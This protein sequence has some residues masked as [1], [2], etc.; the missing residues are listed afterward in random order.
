MA[1]LAC[2]LAVLWRSLTF[3]A[4]AGGPVSSGHPP[5][6]RVLVSLVP[7]PSPPPAPSASIADVAPAS[8][9]LPS[10]PTCQRAIELRVALL[11]PLLP[12]AL[13]DRWVDTLQMSI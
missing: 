3:P 7:P 5:S 8:A 6:E 4:A 10:P 13:A 2:Q 1:E 11:L 12:V 9:V